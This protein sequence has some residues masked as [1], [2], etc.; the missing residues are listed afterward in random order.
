MIAQDAVRRARN[1]FY[2][3]WWMYAYCKSIPKSL[4]PLYIVVCDNIDDYRLAWESKPD[5]VRA[6]IRYRVRTL[7]D[8]VEEIGVSESTLREWINS[9]VVDVD[10]RAL[11]GLG[12]FTAEDVRVLLHHKLLHD[13]QVL[14][15]DPDAWLDTPNP[16]VGGVAPRN[17]LGT[18]Q[19]EIV[20]DAIESIEHG[21]VS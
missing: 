14:F 5:N 10:L 16:Y 20:R 12:T 15:E 17:L 19:Q 6:Q 7:G 3:M 8:V 9:Q 1:K 13:I 21:M 11:R 2:P 4:T 18:D